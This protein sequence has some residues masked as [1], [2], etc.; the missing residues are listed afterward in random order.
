MTSLTRRDP[1]GDA[2]VILID[3]QS[4]QVNSVMPMDRYEL[5]ANVVRLARDVHGTRRLHI[6]RC[7]R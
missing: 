3:Y 2:A 7:R 1:V 5:V 6:G 4:A